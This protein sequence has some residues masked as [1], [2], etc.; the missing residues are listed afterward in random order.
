MKGLVLIIFWFFAVAGLWAEFVLLEVHWNLFDWNPRVDFQGLAIV[1]ALCVTL[2]VILLLCRGTNLP[3][4]RR[5]SFLLCAAL[6]GLGIYVSGPEP[7]TESLFS[8]E[9]SSPFW[10][11]GCRLAVLFLPLILWTVGPSARRKEVRRQV[12]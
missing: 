6:V 12:I 4:G 9:Q 7:K 3:A 8:R 1:L 5:I 10:Y 2:A 11:R